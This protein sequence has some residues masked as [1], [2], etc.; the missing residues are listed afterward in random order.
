MKAIE[1]FGV[2][3][4]VINTASA[5]V[6]SQETSLSIGWIE[7]ISSD[8]KASGQYSKNI[9]TGHHRTVADW[10]ML[11]VKGQWENLGAYSHTVSGEEGDVWFKAMGTVYYNLS[12]SGW[13]GWYDLFVNQN[14]LVSELHNMAGVAYRSKIANVKV[15]TG[16]ALDYFSGHTPLGKA[17]G[18]ITPAFRLTAN[19]SLTEKVQGFV[20]INAHLDRDTKALANSFTGWE[21]TGNQLLIGVQ[22][23]WTPKWRLNVTYRRFNNW[24]G[25]AN[26]G[27]SVI[28]T[29]GYTF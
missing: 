15:T 2:F 23:Q 24:G 21:K 16:I 25:Y 19:T 13:M 11:S 18:V 10:G 22:Y 5:K 1:I 17:E 7:E 12:D 26:D 29:M 20:V 9:V 4:C 8:S 28:T 6:L 27:Q 3:I 14:Q